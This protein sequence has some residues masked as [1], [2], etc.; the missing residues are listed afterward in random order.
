MPKLKVAVTVDRAVLQA[1]DRRVAQGRYQSR[2][3]AVEEALSLLLEREREGGS[4]LAALAMLD[5]EEEVALA[6]EWLQG[7]PW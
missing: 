5:P 1:V 4:L 3:Q 6:E 2:S 7:E